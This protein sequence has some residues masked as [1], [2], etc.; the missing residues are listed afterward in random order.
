MNARAKFKLTEI[1]MHDGAPDSRTFVFYAVYD[2]S[3]PE[4]RGFA[5]LTPTGHCEIRVTNP[6]IIENFKL[7]QDYYLDFSL[8]SEN[9]EAQE[10][11]Q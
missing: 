10:G 7:G 6:F 11:R 5:T 4:D 2:M 9:T 1:R 8:C 3:I